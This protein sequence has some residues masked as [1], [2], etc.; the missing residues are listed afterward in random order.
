M[1]LDRF[2]S[3]ADRV[4]D[5]FVSGADRIGLTPN[6]ISW[7]AL[8]LAVGAALSFALAGERT[9]LYAPAAVVVLASGACDVLD[10]ALAR[11]QGSSSRAGDFLDHVLDRYAD[12][13]IVAGLAVGIGRLDLG[14]AAITGV[15]FTS[16]LGTQAQAVGL[17]RAYG[18]ALG[19]ADRLALAAVV[20]LIAATDVS[21]AGHSPIAWLLVIFA[22]A[23]HATAIQRF[24]VAYRDLREN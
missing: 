21:L 7:L 23:G 10:G 4:I 22:L 1:T 2:R 16:Y 11:H 17:N 5:P 18:G 3:V 12:L 24:I 20:G 19:R 15:V 6:A 13:A 14:F 8:V 9:L